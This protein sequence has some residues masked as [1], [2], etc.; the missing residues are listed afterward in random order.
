MERDPEALREIVF[1]RKVAAQK[2][3]ELAKAGRAAP[4]VDNVRL[5]PAEH[6][7]YLALAYREEKFPKPRNFIGMA[8]ELPVPEMEKLMKAHIRVTEGDLRQLAID[9]AAR[10]RDFLATEGKVESRRM[11]LVEPKIL[12]PTKKEK[13]K[14]SRVDFLIK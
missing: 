4:A 13:L 12:A 3:K 5:E 8:K 10:V 2:V 11:F 1:R 14:D 7:K 9:R 6:A